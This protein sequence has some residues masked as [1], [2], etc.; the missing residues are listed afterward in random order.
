MPCPLLIGYIIGRMPVIGNRIFRIFRSHIK[1]P[2]GSP[3]DNGC[4][5]CKKPWRQKGKNHRR[6]RS[7]TERTKNSRNRPAQVFIPLRKLP[8]SIFSDTNQPD[9][10]I[11][12]LEYSQNLHTFA[13]IRGESDKYTG[14]CSH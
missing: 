3:F 8:F 10:H 6:R 12:D 11:H 4:Y 1:P 5:L 13:E 9:S 7:R 14:C 2:A